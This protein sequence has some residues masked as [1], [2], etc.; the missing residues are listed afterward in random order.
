MEMEKM[1]AKSSGIR[2]LLSREKS[3]VPLCFG[4]DP[5][6]LRAPFWT[7]FNSLGCGA[8]GKGTDIIDHRVL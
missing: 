2:D 3:R 4:R 8:E 7:Y 5:L 6:D 1:Y